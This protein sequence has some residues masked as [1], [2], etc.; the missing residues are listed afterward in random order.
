MEL[1]KNFGLDPLLLGAQIINFLIVFALLKRF[2]YKPV[3]DLLK[4]RQDKILEGIKNAEEAAALLKRT[5]DEEK[6]I[7]IEAQAQGSKFIEEAKN[8]TALM[9][10]QSEEFAKKQEERILKEAKNQIQ[11]EIKEVEARLAGNTSRLAVQFLQ[12]AL[13][14]LFTEKEQKELLKNAL[15][16]MKNTL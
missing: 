8:Q 6:Q 10:K 15:M 3:L 5:K 1:I 4:K 7:L 9:I 11:Q 2:L 16:R 14:E 12:K 13:K